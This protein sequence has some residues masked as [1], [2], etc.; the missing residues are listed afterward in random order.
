MI[1]NRTKPLLKCPWCDGYSMTTNCMTFGNRWGIIFD[2]TRVVSI[3]Y[4]CDTIL[5]YYEYDNSF[6]RT[7]P[8]NMT[9]Y[10]KMEQIQPIWKLDY[11]WDCLVKP[12]KV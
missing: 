9:A 4:S 7:G 1:N 10:L 6:N 11:M 12:E 8:H 5:V 2:N 3:R